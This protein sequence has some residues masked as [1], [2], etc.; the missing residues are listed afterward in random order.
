MDWTATNAY[1]SCKDLE[2]DMTLIPTVDGN[3]IEIALGSSDKTH[4]SSKHRK[5]TM[6]SMY[7]K[8]FENAPDGKSR[9]CRFCGQN[10]SIATATGN[11]GRHLSSRHPGYEKTGDD[12]HLVPAPLSAVT[13]VKKPQSQGKV[14]AQVHAHT[15]AQAIANAQSSCRVDYDHLNWLVIKWLISAALPISTV[16]EKS[17]MN[18]Y[19]FLNPSVNMWQGEKYTAVVLEVFRSMQDDVRDVLRHVSSKVSITLELWNS[20]EKMLFMSITG[21]WIDENW[22]CRKMLL[23]ICRVPHPCGGAEIYLL[24]ERCLK[25]YDLEDRILTC[26]HDNSQNAVHACQTLKEDLDDRR[27]GPFCYIPCAASTLNFMIDDALR[28]MRPII[29]KAREFVLELNGSTM[30]MDDFTQFAATYQEGS[31]KLPLDASSRWNG[32]YQMLDIIRKASRSMEA[33]SRKYDETLGSRVLLGSM[34]KNA[35]NVVHTYLEPFHKTTTN[36]SS[37][38]VSTLGLVLFFMEHVSEMISTCR[39]SHHHPEWLK[40]AAEEMAKKSRSYSNQVCNDFAYTTAILDPRIK[41]ELIPESMN[42]DNY[43]EEARAHFMRNY[44]GSPFPSIGGT[45]AA[46]EIDD[47]GGVSFVEEIARKK[48]RVNLSNNLADELTQ[49][50]TESP[51]PISTDVLEWWKLNS[52]RYPRLCLMAR[53]YLATQANAASPEEIFSC[54]GE[55]VEKNRFCMPREC[56]QVLLCIKSWTQN[57]LKLKYK[58]TEIDFDRLMDVASAAWAECG[59][60]SNNKKQKSMDKPH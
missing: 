14:P 40:N 58:S 42:M 47:D 50:L 36:L 53:D 25:M 19:R 3:G 55:E 52:I 22:S 6:T 24:M 29:A 31:W 60:S 28:T 57:G 12:A 54:K 35:A 46:Q 33:V 15:Q 8:Y 5:K 27:G 2:P 44:S 56:A 23:D 30:M 1:K 38:K 39:D 26:T 49:Y 34:E 13:I 20:Y 17:L 51:A 16:E 18:S 41:N 9:S 10:Y 7:L 43:L 37:M 59:A 45:Y 11:L 21:H 4:P 32:C 48:R